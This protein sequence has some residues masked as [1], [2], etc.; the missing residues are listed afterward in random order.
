MMKVFSAAVATSLVLAQAAWAEPERQQTG[1]ET[2][3]TSISYADL[4]LASRA[5]AE[6]MLYRLQIAARQVCDDFAGPRP[7]SERTHIQDCVDVALNAAVRDLHHP[8]VTALYNTRRHGAG[9][10]LAAR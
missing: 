4:N 7:L 8:T 6:E 2:P 9:S 1:A 5:G 10:E 3:S